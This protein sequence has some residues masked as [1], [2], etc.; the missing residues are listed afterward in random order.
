M[1]AQ[2]I[3]ASTSAIR[4]QL[5][6][7]AGVSFTALPPR[8]DEQA[9]KQALADEGATPRDVADTLAEYKARKVSDKNPGA[10]VI[11]A[12]QVLEIGGEI[13]DKPRDAEEARAQLLRLRGR[14]HRLLSAAVIYRDG[15]PLWRTVGIVRLTMR[16]FSDEFL[17][18][19]MGRN[20]AGLTSSVGGYKLEEEGVRLFSRVEG[21]YFSVLGLP[22]VEILNYLTLQG[23]IDG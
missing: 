14:P 15:E 18:D 2:I 8:V 16:D 6:E 23:E 13:L 10:L 17:S 1:A 21:D 11:G 5:L 20:G 22:L 19:Y 12:D 9:I 4:R 7:N 3:L